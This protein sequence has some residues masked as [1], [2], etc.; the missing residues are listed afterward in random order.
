MSM[1]IPT[2]CPNCGG[3]EL[4][5]RRVASSHEM[6][7]LGGLGG[8][9]RFAKFRVLLC[10]DCGNISLFAEEDARQ[11]VRDAGEWQRREALRPVCRACGYDLRSTPDRC[12]ECGAQQ[13]ET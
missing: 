6:P 1:S 8:F 9:L 10:A 3:K 7:I 4:F 11:K 2:E 13:S 5:T 12:P